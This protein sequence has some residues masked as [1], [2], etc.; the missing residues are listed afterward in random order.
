M[1]NEEPETSRVRIYGIQQERDL[2]VPKSP[3][4]RTG[5]PFLIH[6]QVARVLIVAGST[7]GFASKS[8][9]RGDLS[10]GKTAARVPAF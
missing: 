2:P 6:S 9:A 10:P 5:S 1:S 3:I 4:R 7:L 8:K